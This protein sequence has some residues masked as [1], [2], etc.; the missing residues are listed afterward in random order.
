MAWLAVNPLNMEFIF[1]NKPV[2]VINKN[3][4]YSYWLDKETYNYIRGITTSA[5]DYSIRLPMGSIK[6]LIGRK[7]TW[8]DEPVEIK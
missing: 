4:N 2:R 8:E 3:P 1:H 7:L 6:K 5:E